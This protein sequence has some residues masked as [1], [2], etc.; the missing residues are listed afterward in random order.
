MPDTYTPIHIHF[1]VAVKN[2]QARMQ[3]P[4]R[5]R[6]EKYITG[7][8][9]HAG[10]KLPAASCMPGPAHLFAGFR[11]AQPI[12]GLM[13]EVKAR[14]SEFIHEERLTKEKFNGQ[15]GY[16]AFSNPHAQVQNVIAYILHPP[17][18]HRKKTFREAY[19]A[20]SEKFEIPYE[21]PYLFNWIEAG[22]AP[23]EPPASSCFC[24]GGAP[25]E[26]IGRPNKKK[27]SVLIKAK[28]KSLMKSAD[29]RSYNYERNN[30][31]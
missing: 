23:A 19:L 30:H 14:S 1:V 7:I 29:Q 25:T 18:H 9:Q 21:N 22:A 15:E 17:E 26:Q 24:Q 6:V 10:H 12:S 8:V 13:R 28:Q 5:V 31:H 27:R 11:P 3:E 2:R 4:I 20:V 16:G